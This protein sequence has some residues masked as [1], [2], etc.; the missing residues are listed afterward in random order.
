MND[1][2]FE[3]LMKDSLESGRTPD[4]ASL[5]RLLNKLSDPVTEQRD[6]RYTRVTATSNITSNTVADVLK[7]WRS[8]RIILVP[9]FVLL[10]LV[11]IFSLSPHA[12]ASDRAILKIAA[13]DQTLGEQEVDDDDIIMPSDFD[14]PALDDLSNTQNEI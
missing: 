1:K 11:G 5:T 6:M 12:S 8:K 7:F 2:E 10:L 13:E 14:S 9:S 3:K 4:H